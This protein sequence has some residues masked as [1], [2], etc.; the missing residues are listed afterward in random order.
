MSL[1]QPEFSANSAAVRVR[2]GAGVR[3]AVGEEMERMGLGRAL[4]LTTPQQA[5]TGAEFAARLGARAVGV[6]S[7]AAMHTPV[8]ISEEATE[9]ARALRADCVVSVGGGS[10]T[11]LGKAIALRSDLP[12]IVVPTTYAGSEAT[13][14]LGQTENGL[15]TTL[16]SAKVQ[17][18]VIL[19][20][21]ELVRSLPVGMTVTSAL[22]AMA[23]AAEGLYAQ[24]RSPISSLMA[25][26][27]IRAFRDALPRVMDNPDDLA[28]RG[29]TL[30]GAWLCGTVLGQVGMALHHK[31]CHTLGGSFDLP[32]AETH[33]VILPHAIAYNQQ[34]AAAELAPV[35]ALFGAASAGDGLYDF[36]VAMKAPLALRDLGMAEADL[37]KAA[38]I[39]TRN[40]YW[41]PRP[42]DKAA[43]RA[44]LQAAW[45]GDRP[46]A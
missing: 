44:L 38:E 1:F 2:F 31:L 6:F 42:L 7:K 24:N 37:D 9:L 45:Q 13:A 19:Y 43:L 28:A 27:G 8:A 29:E 34:A 33:A 26:E 3:H 25:I 20:D 40:A 4:V 5:D 16:T 46:A 36:A 12:Q 21:A 32:H 22:N 23:H 14:I 18:E 35:A 15:K 39:A 41:N 10:T 17:P 11:G 30:Y